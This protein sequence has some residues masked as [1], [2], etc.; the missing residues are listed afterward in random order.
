MRGISEF[1]GL[2]FHKEMIE[3]YR[4]RSTRMTDGI[5]PLSKMLGDVKFHEH[6]GIESDLADRWREKRSDYSLSKLTWRMAQTLGYEVGEE[7][8]TLTGSSE[9]IE[10]RTKPPL[11]RIQ[12]DGSRQPFFCAHAAGGQVLGYVELARR[13]GREQPFY[14]FQAAG[15][16]D[17]EP[18]LRTV[19][20]MA[21]SYIEAMKSIRP[22][23]PYLLGGWSV[24]GVVAYEM[25]RQLEQRGEEVSLLVLMDSV[26]PP[27]FKQMAQV[28]DSMLMLAFLQDIGLAVNS[29]PV[30]AESLER[31]K[32][33][34][35]LAF[36]LEAAKNARLM[37]QDI[38]LGT[39]QRLFDVFKANI[40]AIRQ[41]SPQG[42]S[43]G[44]TLLK[45][46]ERFMAYDFDPYAGWTELARKG[47]RVQETPG[48][49][50]TML[51]EP[52]VRALADHL[53]G[54]LEDA[55]SKTLA[56]Y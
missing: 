36:A 6:K 4:D 22:S 40:E 30:T 27:A 2:E 7:A 14:G 44:V 12:P 25:A 16:D 21:T 13:V 48:N 53:R 32:P 35:R 29:L 1:L 28:D 37:P 54:C 39:V 41:Y 8:A 42:C 34:G 18:P 10:S 20:G 55:Q 33:E 24:G 9:R 26:A 46:T 52:N 23:G 56:A 51:K 38:S 31:I 11:V 3:P 45:A 49:H 17:G 19:E 50:Y 47:V 43:V 5:H 15:L